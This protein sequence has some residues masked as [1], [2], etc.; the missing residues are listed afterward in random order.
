MNLNRNARFDSYSIRTQTVDL[1]VP[2]DK[3]LWC[4]AYVCV[5]VCVRL[6]TTARHISLDGKGNALYPVLSDSKL[7]H[8]LSVVYFSVNPA[9]CLLGFSDTSV[10][11]LFCQVTVDCPRVLRKTLCGDATI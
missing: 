1:C 9:S 4:S 2:M 8:F 6:V 5:C 11:I 7:H 10:N 3:V